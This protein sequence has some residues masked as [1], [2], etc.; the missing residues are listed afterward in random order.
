MKAG[1]ALENVSGAASLH[2]L[3]RTINML[4]ILVSFIAYNKVCFNYIYC[5]PKN[6]LFYARLTLVV[7]RRKWCAEL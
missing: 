1:D 3:A 5:S 2:S 6:D 4:K 7:S